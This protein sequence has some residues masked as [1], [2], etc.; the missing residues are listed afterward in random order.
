ML[1]KYLY[2]LT[3]WIAL[4]AV[5][6]TPP[7]AALTDQDRAAITTLGDQYLQ[8]LVDDN[9]TTLAALFVEDGI[10]LVNNG[11]VTQGRASI[12]ADRS[13]IDFLTFRTDN[14]TIGGEGALAYSWMD[15]DMTYVVS[16]GA[17]PSNFYGRFLTV[18]KK[19]LDGT[20]LYVAVMFNPRPVT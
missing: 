8:A 15:Y 16:E 10:R 18:T 2:F 19:Q 7:P 14:I 11:P 17:E 13:P 5:A 4:S 3:L 9:P 12:E 1:T 20:W 6:C